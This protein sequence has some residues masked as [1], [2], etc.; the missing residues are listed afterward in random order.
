[1]WIKT[2][3]A[4]AALAVLSGCAGQTTQ[5]ETAPTVPE[6][7]YTY[8]TPKD[9]P[10][11]QW[12]TAMLVSHELMGIP[13][14]KDAVAP[15]PGTPGYSQR[16][17]GA[18]ALSVSALGVLSPTTHISGGGSLALG[19][20]MF[21][22]GGGPT[23]IAGIAQL[24]FWVPADMADNAADASK[25]AAS[26]WAEIRTRVGKKPIPSQPKTSAYPTNHKLSH[27]S[28]K[29]IVTSTP[30][31]FEGDAK[32]FEVGN[33]DGK[34]YGPIFIYRLTGQLHFDHVRSKLSWPEL[35][36]VYADELPDWAALYF[37]GIPQ[38]E[39]R[40]VIYGGQVNHFISHTA[41]PL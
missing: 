3:L 12:S 23:E 31:P 26:T 41:A 32:H 16:I 28:L 7:E 40:S 24:A 1:M 18:D 2:G 15:A 37:H 30:A 6:V 8:N 35:L 20:G 34:F 39:P 9:T 14:V 17:S 22:L 13:G 4:V 11:E 36:Q 33:L 38:E 21:L 19:T 5:K 29:D 10:R 25:I 27:A